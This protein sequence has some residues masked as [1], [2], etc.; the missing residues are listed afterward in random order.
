M[1]SL[2]GDGDRASF[3]CGACAKNGDDAESELKA[4]ESSGGL[5]RPFKAVSV[6]GH[7]VD[8]FIPDVADK[9]GDVILAVAC[10]R[11]S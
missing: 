8:A 10:A 7:A 5:R 9:T 1:F 2:G 3:G 11:S 6:L 4:G